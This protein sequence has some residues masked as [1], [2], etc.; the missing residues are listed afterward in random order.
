MSGRSARLH[1]EFA[2]AKIVVEK[3]HIPR[4]G[5]EYGI[6]GHLRFHDPLASTYPKIAH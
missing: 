2:G 4:D 1:T 6:S 5:V 3:A